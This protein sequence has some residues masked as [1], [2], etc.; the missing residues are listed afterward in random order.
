MIEKF[1]LS[2][3]DISIETHAGFN[4]F[5]LIATDRR[6]NQRAFSYGLERSPM[7]CCIVHIR[8]DGTRFNLGQYDFDMPYETFKQMAVKFAIEQIYDDRC[9]PHRT[10]NA[11]ATAAVVDKISKIGFRALVIHK[12]EQTLSLIHI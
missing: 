12:D 4:R 2:S 10:L 8:A 1:G 6:T 7:T 9:I 11:I 5:V 3:F